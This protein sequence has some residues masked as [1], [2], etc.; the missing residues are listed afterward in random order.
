M[1]NYRER[2]GEGGNYGGREREREGRKGES[3]EGG[4]GRGEEREVWVGE[5]Q[6]RRCRGS[7][8][9]ELREAREKEMKIKL[10][11]HP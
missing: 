6:S 10:Y 4:G 2:K 1:S 3:K 7:Y 8:R 11:K 9:S 5:E